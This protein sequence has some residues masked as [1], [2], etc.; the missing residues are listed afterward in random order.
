MTN[1]FDVIDA[2]L[3]NIENMLLEIS[4]EPRLAGNGKSDDIL[5]VPQTAEFLSL[6]VPTIYSLISRGDLP[7]MRRNGR[8]YF[9]RADL[10]GYLKAGRVKT[11]YEIRAEAAAYSENKKGRKHG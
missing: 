1:P 7:A 6:A 9:S 2:R 8:V 10:I 5:T 11:N 4:H 3:S